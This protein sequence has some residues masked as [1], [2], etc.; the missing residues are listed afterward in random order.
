MSEQL[1]ALGWAVCSCDTLQEHPTD[2]LDQGVRKA[3]LA[4]IGNYVY[5]SVFLG[6]PCETYSAL[7]SIPP[8]PRPLRTGA[9]ITGIS[10][11]LN[12]KEKKQLEEGNQHTGFSSRVMHQAHTYLVP[13]TMENPEPINEVSIFKMP[14]VVSVAELREVKDTNFDQCR[15]G[16]EARKPTRLLHYG[17]VYSE[18]SEL[19]CDHPVQSFVDSKGQPYQASHERVAQRKRTKSDGSWEYASKALGNY[20]P[21]LCKALAAAMAGVKSGRSDAARELRSQPIP[22]PTYKGPGDGPTERDAEDAA[23]LGGMRSPDASIKRLPVSAEAGRMLRELLEAGIKQYPQLKHTACDI[24]RGEPVVRE[25]DEQA[26]EEVKGAALKLLAA[27]APVP[28]KTAPADSPINA[29]LLWGWGEHTDDPDAQLLAKWVLQGAPL[30]FDHPI[31]TVGVFPKVTGTPADAPELAE[32]MRPAEGW[33]NWPSAVEEAEDLEKLVKEAEAKGFCTVTWDAREA[34]RCLGGPPVLNRLGVVVK[35]QGDKKK[36]RIVWDMRESGVNTRCNPAE[37]ILLPRLL[38]VVHDTLNI[39]RNG[40]SPSYAAVDIQDAF[41][42]IPANEDRRY[43]V[44]AAPIDGELAHIIYNVLVF[45]SK[46]SPT[47]WGRYAAF[48]GRV[49]ACVVPENKTQVYVDDPIWVIP[50]EGEAAEELL[51]LAILTTLVFGFPLKLAKASAGKNH[52]VDRRGAWSGIR[53]WRRLRQGPDTGRESFKASAGG[54]RFSW[55]PRSWA[56]GNCVPSQ[57]ACRSWRALSRSSGRFWLRCGRLSPRSQQMTASPAGKLIH[58][59]RIAPQPTLDTCAATQWARATRE[60]V[61]SQVSRWRLGDHH[62]RMP[63]GNRWGPVQTRSPDKVVRIRAHEATAGKVQGKEGR[64]GI[65]YSLGSLGL[66]S[67]LEAVARKV[68]EAPISSG[69]VGQCGR[70]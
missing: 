16:C 6:T 48:L 25:M 70:P 8:G 10:H 61:P 39:L 40:G 30:G 31:T 52:Q 51:T 33:E 65:Q 32:I 56:Q 47:I 21:E 34:D 35:M 7:R 59:K 68:P 64:P 9:E 49:L 43:T 22:W 37:R 1:K 2:L 14:E 28:R 18:L 67:G 5:D 57:A 19:R 17:V 24:I 27:E 66:T 55:R 69:Q 44:A 62:G 50:A 29:H 15:F 46:S 23:A 4:D 26:L 11:G 63:L 13:F 36:S 38:D 54:G 42:N 45:G 12:A 3:I 58:L 53:R 20:T 60:E 41:H